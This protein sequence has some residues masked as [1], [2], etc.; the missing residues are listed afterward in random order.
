M[1]EYPKH[2]S[3]KDKTSV[4]LRPL[5]RDDEEKLMKFFKELLQEDRLYLK[6]DVTKSG[7][8]GKW[9]KEL[10]Y[11]KVFPIVAILE[12]RIIADGTLHLYGFGWMRYLGEIRL[13]V[14]KDFQ[15]KGLGALIISELVGQALKKG[16]HRIQ[17]QFA[18]EQISA[19]KAFERVGFVKEAVLKKHVV[20][21]NGRETDLVIMTNDVTELWKK[22]EDIYFEYDVKRYE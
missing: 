16:L 1:A 21:L 2:I 11:D 19:I 17:T 22:L 10:D 6:E 5:I 15:R 4:I 14:A 12:D 13:S 9:I 3:L 7:V 8:I 18:S 20:D